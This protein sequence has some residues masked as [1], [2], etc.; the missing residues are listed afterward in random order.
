M[1]PADYHE[2]ACRLF[3]I[4]AQ[5]IGALDHDQNISTTGREENNRHHVGSDPETSPSVGLLPVSENINPRT[6]GKC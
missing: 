1:L 4:A 5:R 6:E 2:R 3:R